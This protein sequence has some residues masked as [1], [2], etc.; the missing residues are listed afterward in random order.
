MTSYSDFS[1]IRLLLPICFTKKAHNFNVPQ[2]FTLCTLQLVLNGLTSMVCRISLISLL[3]NIV[4][5]KHKHFICT[6]YP[7]DPDIK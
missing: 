3:E 6:G 1:P 4:S 2:I 5:I 7:T